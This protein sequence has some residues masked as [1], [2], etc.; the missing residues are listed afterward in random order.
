[1]KLWDVAPDGTK[2]LVTRGVYRLAEA[3]GDPGT[4]TIDTKLFGNMWHFTAGHLIQLQVTQVDAPYLRPDNIPSS[5][6]FG[7]IRLV[8]PVREMLRSVALVPA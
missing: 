6:A 8:L 7:S 4:G 3:G 1:L 2:T 5:I